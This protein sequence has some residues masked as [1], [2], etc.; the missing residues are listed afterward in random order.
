MRRNLIIRSK[1]S[2][3]VI[4]DAL[5]EQYGAAFKTLDNIIDK[6][7]DSL[8][9]DDSNGP[10]FYKIIYHILYFADLYL[11]RTKEERSTFKPRFEFAEDFSISKENFGSAYWKK[12]LSKE[13]CN[14]YLSEIRSKAHVFFQQVSIAEL[15]SEPLFEWHGSSLLGSLIYNIRHVMLHIGTLQGRLRLNGFEEKLWV[16]K[17]EILL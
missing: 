6:C 15:I 9:K 7:S 10:P 5:V 11:S 13:E 8:W 4:R 16:T 2:I 14:L 17:S 3:I 1:D 12:P